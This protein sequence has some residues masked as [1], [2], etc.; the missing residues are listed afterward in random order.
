MDVRQLESLANRCRRE[1]VRM[2]YR[3]KAGHIGGSLSAADILTALYFGV[4]RIRPEEPGWP[5]RDFFVLSKGHSVESYYAVLA[6]RGYFSAA[7]LAEYSRFGS[8]FTGH[9]NRKV[10]GVD[11]GTGAL[12]HGLPVSVGLA[13]AARRDGRPCRVFALM[14][15]GEM[16]EGS[17]WEAA[18][19]GAKYGLDNLTVIVDRNGLQI[20]GRT[21]A[22]MPLENMAEKWKAFGWQVAETDGHRMAELVRVLGRAG[23]GRPR[24]I[25]AHTVKGRGVSFME[26]RAEW[27]HGVLDRAQYETA[28][29]ELE[30][31]AGKED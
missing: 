7:R 3:A 4:M 26:N 24:L 17:N 8:D 14:G 1:A 2:V 10:P 6:M 9:P 21:E 19:A 13:L 12:G 23:A 28:M 5:D 25:V 11:M 15:D 30:A 16:E 18:M 22:V 27:H 31:A 29:R 20:S